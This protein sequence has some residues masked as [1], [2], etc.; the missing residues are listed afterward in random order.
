MKSE[1]EVTQS[2]PALREPYGLQP[3]RLLHPWD[4]PGFSREWG[5][6]TFSIWT[7]IKIIGAILI[8]SF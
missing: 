2:C 5:A 7:P 6:I 1:S 3:S 8:K 4:F